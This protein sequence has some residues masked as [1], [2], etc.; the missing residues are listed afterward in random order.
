QD[1]LRCL[2]GGLRS[3]LAVR[4]TRTASLYLTAPPSFGCCARY[5]RP[6]AQGGVAGVQGSVP[7][8]A[9][10]REGRCAA[11][12]EAPYRGVPAAVR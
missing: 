10:H 5:R 4:C 9:E 6:K 8:E 7:E 11:S 12:G 2:R 1:R 3:W